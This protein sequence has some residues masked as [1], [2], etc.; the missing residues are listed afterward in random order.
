M[1]IL[2]LFRKPIA[3]IDFQKILEC[4]NISK[5]DGIVIISALDLRT[6]NT[7]EKLEKLKPLLNEYYLPC[8]Y[9]VYVDKDLDLNSCINI[10][11][12]TSRMFG[13]KL[14]RQSKFVNKE[15][16]I[17]YKI[18]KSNG[19]ERTLSLGRSTSNITVQFD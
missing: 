8:K 10:L 19:V 17:F 18:V 7:V 4:F 12:Q 9:R 3:Y 16:Q 14:L 15:K 2:Q 1:K 11:R 5:I 13:Y 6:H